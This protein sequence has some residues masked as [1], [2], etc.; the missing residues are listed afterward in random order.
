MNLRSITDKV[1]I[2]LDAMDAE[3]GDSGIVRPGVALEAP[4]FG[5]VMS[6]GAGIR[7]RYDG[8]RD[9][10]NVEEGDRV[11]VPWG[12]GRKYEVMGQQHVIMRETD[13][14]AVVEQ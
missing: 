5:T 2:R 11:M 3:F 13:I 14:I 4:R 1:R 6:V 12:T 8:G 9:P 10:V 7:R